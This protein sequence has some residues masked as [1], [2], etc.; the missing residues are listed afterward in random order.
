VID[1]LVTAPAA[2][3]NAIRFRY[4]R[5]GSPEEERARIE[6]ALRRWRGNKT[7]AAAELGM[8][9]NT[10][11]EKMRQL[12]GTDPDSFLDPAD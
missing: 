4:S 7:R 11:R 12:A 10:L 1:P 3:A 2:H 5:F 6:A 9:R 8:A